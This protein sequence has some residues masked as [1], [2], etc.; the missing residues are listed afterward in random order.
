MTYEEVIEERIRFL[1]LNE[2][3]ASTMKQVEGPIE[4]AMDDLLEIAE[5]DEELAA[6]LIMKAREHWFAE[7]Q[8]A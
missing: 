6:A 3:T 2:T 5:M 7:E 8:Q 4:D 1:Q